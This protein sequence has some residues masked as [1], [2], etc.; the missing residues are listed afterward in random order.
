[1]NTIRL[2]RVIEVIRGLVNGTLELQVVQAVNA[3][4]MRKGRPPKNKVVADPDPNHP[5]AEKIHR[6]LGR[7]PDH[8]T[9]KAGKPAA[10]SSGKFLR[11]G[12]KPMTEAAKAKKAKEIQQIKARLAKRA[13]PSPR[14]IFLFLKGKIDG[15]KASGIA[16]HFEVD[17]GLLKVLLNKLVDKHDLDAQAGRFF[18]K[19]RIRTR[20]TK[21]AVSGKPVPVSEEAVLNYLEKSGA[22]TLQQMAKKM[23]EPTF[24]R[25]IRVVNRLKRAGKVV[26]EGKRYWLATFVPGPTATPDPILPGNEIVSDDEAKN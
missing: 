1:M 16:K 12:R 5:K 20:D 21:G 22:E 25:L 23:G 4:P 26:V 2:D 15:V 10:N 18:L 9:L 24:H 3:T 7:P 6:R 13:L 19:R 14:S 17:R 8:K 11:R